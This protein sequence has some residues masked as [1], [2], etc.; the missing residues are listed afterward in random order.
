MRLFRYTK[1]QTQCPGVTV[2]DKHYDL[3][4]H[5][6]DIDR[7]FFEDGGLEKV[8]ALLAQATLPIIENPEFTVPIYRPGK[9]ACVGLNYRAHAVESGMDVPKE[10]VVFFKAT[11]SL[12]G[13]FDDVIIPRGS[14]KTDW[15][16]ELAVIIGKRAS[17]ITKDE[18]LDYVAGYAVHNDISERTF[19]FEHGGQWVKGKSCDT[20]APLGPYIVTKDEIP[21]PH[22]LRL[23][24]T[25][26]GETVQDSNTADFVFDIPTVLSYLSQFMTFEPG[27]IIST[28][29]P[30]GVGFG[31]NP[32]RYLR[33]GDVMEL[34]IE[35]LGIAKQ[36]VIAYSV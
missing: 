24:L 15:E 18:A 22:N 34:G 17:Y 25:V 30:S 2:G 20:F 16:V 32:P 28:G 10:P 21:N 6:N 9:I 14:E 12:C 36:H 31:F 7:D 8:A 23:W 5:I 1:N 35:G 27:D 13:P 26:N 3:S 4:T 33:P 11:S 19:Q 29:T